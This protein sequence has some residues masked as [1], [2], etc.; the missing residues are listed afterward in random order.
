[1]YADIPKQLRDAIERRVKDLSPEA[2]VRAT[3]TL[4]ERYRAPVSYNSPIARSRREVLAYAAY[5]LPAT[6]AAVTAAL[7][8]ARD[9]RPDWEPRTLL[10]LGSGLG[11]GTWAA[12]QVWP[13][14][15][16]VTA[17]EAE[18]EMIALGKHFGQ[19]SSWEAVRTTN[20]IKDDL[21]TAEVEQ[22]N[23]LVLMSYVLGELNPEA[24]PETVNKAW[25]LATGMLVIVEPGTPSGYSRIIRARNELLCRGGFVTAPCPHD[26]PCPMGGGDWC[27]FAVRLP[28][29]RTHR[30]AKQS[31]LGYEDEKYSY[32]AVSREAT[33]RTEAR[34][35]R[36]P[37]ISP[38]KVTLELCTLEG[39]KS[40]TILKR[41]REWFKRGR[42]S[43]WGDSFDEYATT[44]LTLEAESDLEK[45]PPTA[46]PRRE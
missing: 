7:V 10:D 12:A 29:S 44:G 32:V 24:I 19:G 22:P 14:I 33:C 40:S 26:A 20:W 8:A 34:I 11:A 23:D 9:Q 37:Q 16:T 2:L 43:E 4:S 35:L 42:K 21:A 31:T 18:E 45:G 36:H 30:I 1:M 13:S 15:D 38:G 6:F 3:A 41:D 25:D 39:L 28:R 5:R 27:H 17:I 46:E